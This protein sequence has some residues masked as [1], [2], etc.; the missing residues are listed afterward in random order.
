MELTLP[1]VNK[2]SINCRFNSVAR[3]R[4]KSFVVDISQ[5]E[6]T[7]DTDSKPYCNATQRSTKRKETDHRYLQNDET[8]HC[9]EKTQRGNL[10]AS[11]SAFNA[12]RI[13]LILDK[14]R[15]IS[16]KHKIALKDRERHKSLIKLRRDKQLQENKCIAYEMR[17]QLK[18]L[19]EKKGYDEGSKRELMSAQK[20]RLN[21][22]EKK[23]K[24]YC[25]RRTKEFKAEKK[26]ADAEK[27]KM[28]KLAEIES[29]M[30]KEL[31]HTRTNKETAVSKLRM[32]LQ[33][34][35]SN[36]E[37]YKKLTREHML[38]IRAGIRSSAKISKAISKSL[39]NN[40]A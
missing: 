15:I 31:N 37:K 1:D 27:K 10:Q 26:L 23:S 16:T 2:S 25:K 22:S 4:R 30:I 17:Q 13:K 8:N 3:E 29:M 21:L 34:Q 14:R 40:L 7:I 36:Y 12:Q 33:A 9:A 20:V 24:L 38:D 5:D 6:S 28:E 11:T 19:K 32:L 18:L 39:D 35:P